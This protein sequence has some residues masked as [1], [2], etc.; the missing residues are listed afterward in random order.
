MKIGSVH[1][2]DMVL[3][4]IDICCLGVKKLENEQVYLD[5]TYA[6][7]YGL[8]EKSTHLQLHRIRMLDF[9]DVN[10]LNTINRIIFKMYSVRK[11]G[12]RKIKH[13]SKTCQC[14]STILEPSSGQHQ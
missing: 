13:H 7:V 11:I 1:C 14:L 3:K 10:V 9:D 4:I 8:R 6:L 5:Q 2:A 12:S